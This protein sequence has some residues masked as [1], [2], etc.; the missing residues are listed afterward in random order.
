MNFGIDDKLKSSLNLFIPFEKIPETG[1]K[2]VRLTRDYEIQTKLME[3]IYPIFEQAKIQE[4]ED[5]PAVLVVDKAVPPEK[6]SAP[7]R[8]LIVAVTFFLSFIFSVGYVIVKE[9]YFS[10]MKDEDRY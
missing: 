9:S 1:I 6:K 10:L 2:Y 7:K 3:F 5:I 8:L 4:Q